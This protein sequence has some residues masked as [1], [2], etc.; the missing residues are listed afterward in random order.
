MSSPDVP[1]AADRRA[2]QVVDHRAV[3]TN[4]AHGCASTRSNTKPPP[5]PHLERINNILSGMSKRNIEAEKDDD[6][7]MDVRVEQGK[8]LV[9][10]NDSSAPL[11]R[12]RVLL[13]I[14]QKKDARRSF[15][16]RP[17]PELPIPCRFRRETKVFTSVSLPSLPPRSLIPPSQ[18]RTSQVEL[19][20]SRAQ[21]RTPGA[22]V[23]NSY[24]RPHP[25][26]H[27]DRYHMESATIPHYHQAALSG[28][29]HYHMMPLV[30]HS[31]PH[32]QPHLSQHR[33]CLMHHLLSC[34]PST[35]AVPFHR[36]NST[37]MQNAHSHS[38]TH[39]PTVCRVGQPPN[40]A[41]R[42][43]S[44]EQERK[45]IEDLVQAQNVS[46]DNEYT[47][48]Q[49]A[50]MTRRML[51]RASV[52]KCRRKQRERANRLE[53]EHKALIHDNE[54]LRRVKVYVEQSGFYDII[55]SVQQAQAAGL[56]PTSIVVTSFN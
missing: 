22:L 43:L 42:I 53:L 26:P 28:V 18:P 16:A 7:V 13:P 52:Q 49:I 15:K 55:R 2:I 31:N 4:S 11:D 25:T 27:V 56:D 51:N 40:G 41:T 33:Y 38:H 34:P 20:V 46:H 35:F 6:E 21:G 39:A 19:G 45:R 10:P 50:R 47:P 1:F 44:T 36:D 32:H 37:V 23:R 48:E 5:S 12:W 30:A 14:I 8:T 29:P 17:H 3:H 54:V 24:S 9:L